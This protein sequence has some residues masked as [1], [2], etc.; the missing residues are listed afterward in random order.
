M[1][2][3][4]YKIVIISILLNACVG[5]VTTLIPELREDVFSF[6]GTMNASK[7]KEEF[8][9]TSDI[10]GSEG[11][12]WFNSFLDYYVVNWVTKLYTQFDNFM[13]GAV[14]YIGSAFGAGL[15]ETGGQCI[16][17]SAIFGPIGLFKMLIGFLYTI[18]II[19]FMLNRNLTK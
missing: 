7:F 12:G 9:V 16:L 5:L 17:R 4:I 13:F 15:C 2:S 11:S 19:E 3:I 1:N 14:N 10:P 18:L 6:D 8:N